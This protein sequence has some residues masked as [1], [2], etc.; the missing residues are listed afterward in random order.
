[1]QNNLFFYDNLSY[2]LCA[3]FHT[4]II[5]RITPENNLEGLQLTNYYYFLN[6]Y[7][8]EKLL[9]Q[10]IMKQCLPSTL[11]IVFIDKWVVIIL[12][13]VI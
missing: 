7:Y 10:H 2:M 8:V 5:H 11:Y 12:I 3:I 6:L 13:C 9:F 4:Q 1:M